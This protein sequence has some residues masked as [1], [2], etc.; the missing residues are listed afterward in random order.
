MLIAAIPLYHMSLYHV[1]TKNYKN[2][3]YSVDK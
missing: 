2:I 3:L 1:I